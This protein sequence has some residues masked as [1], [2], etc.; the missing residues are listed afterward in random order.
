MPTYTVSDL[1]RI[2]GAEIEG[3]PDR[4]LRD[5]APLETAGPEDLTFFARTSLRAHA[6]KTNAGAL[7]ATRTCD[8]EGVASS[9]LRVDDPE[10]AFAQLLPLFRPGPE[11]A[12]GIHP[13]ATLGR[14]VKIGA[15]VTLAANV[16][17]EAGAEI[18]QGTRIGPSTLIGEG[19]RLGRDCRIGH[20]VSIL[21]RVRIGDRVIVHPGARIGTD[22]FGYAAT[23]AGAHKIPQVGG[24]VIGDD[25]EVGANCTIDRG[26]L[27]DTTIGDRSKLDN[28]VHVAHNVKI[29][30]DC[31]IVAQV[32]IAGSSEIGRGAQLGGQVGVIGHLTIGPGARIAAGSG[33]MRD[34]PE[35]ATQGGA[36]AQS[37]AQWLRMI[38]ASRKLPELVRRVAA[39]ERR[40]ASADPAGPDAKDGDGAA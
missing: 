3:D 16:V 18:G 9:V 36:P 39:I 27:G 6:E 17:V 26:S 2:V 1:A 23:P 38:A 19:A 11:S 35:G 34:V 31:M 30:S 40:T 4:R 5:V 8:L 13:S 15:D 20:G 22:G 32:G 25:V 28:L 10:L 14:G 21:H 7:L 29:E 24:C 37:H 33:V 12:S